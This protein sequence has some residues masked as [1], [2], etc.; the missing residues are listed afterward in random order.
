MQ[1]CKYLFCW[2][3]DKFLSHYQL[4]QIDFSFAPVY[5]IKPLGKDMADVSSM[6]N[7]GRSK[8]TNLKSATG[9]KRT[10]YFAPCTTL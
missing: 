7:S 8:H 2:A 4:Q 9:R 5:P 10:K 1:R 3:L 6:E